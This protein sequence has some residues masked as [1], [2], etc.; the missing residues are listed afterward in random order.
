MLTLNNRNQID[1]NNTNVLIDSFVTFKNNSLVFIFNNYHHIIN[2]TKINLDK[3]IIVYNNN[4]LKY[5]ALNK[6]NNY[7][8]IEDFNPIT[9]F[10][11]RFHHEIF[12]VDNFTKDYFI[13]SNN[14]FNLE[15]KLNDCNNNCIVNKI[16]TINSINN[17]FLDKKCVTT[18]YNNEEDLIPSWI[19][20]HKNIGFE[21]FIIYDNNFNE[22]KFNKLSISIQKYIDDVFIINANWNYWLNSY[23]INSVGQCIQQNHCIWK[24][25]PKFLLLTD[26]DEYV[27][28]QNNCN[29]FDENK[30]IT[31]IPNWFFGCNNNITYNNNNFI[32]KLT[33]KTANP[34]NKTQRKCLIQS[35]YVDLFCVHVPI[36]FY[37][38]INYLDYNE[39]YLNHYYILSSKKRQC[40]CQIYCEIEDNSILKNCK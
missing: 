28:I 9:Y 12:I 30:F 16:L 20:Y 26:L 18:I 24:F 11:N 22:D 38:N 15:I 40:I 37:K 31:S 23:G 3:T 2:N 35:Q 14:S 8:A 36:I 34:N 25:C 4:V 10:T 17:E 13:D 5:K 6:F 21:K 32:Q 39:C 33:K 19:E 1:V 27:N 7:N 29:L